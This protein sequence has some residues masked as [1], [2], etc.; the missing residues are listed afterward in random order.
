MQDITPLQTAKKLIKSSE[1][2]PQQLYSSQQ[3]T[4]R[5]KMASTMHVEVE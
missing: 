2:S 4:H 1:I 3:K 5:L